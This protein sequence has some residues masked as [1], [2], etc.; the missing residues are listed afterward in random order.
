MVCFRYVIEN[1]LHKGG[2]GDDSS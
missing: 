2:S 1:T